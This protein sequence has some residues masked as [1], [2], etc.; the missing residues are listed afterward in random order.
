M[1]QLIHPVPPAATHASSLT[2]LVALAVVLALVLIAG[3]V[4]LAR[5]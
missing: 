4:I 2:P 1:P 3:T 5:R